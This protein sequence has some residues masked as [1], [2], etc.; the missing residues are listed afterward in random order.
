M[1]VYE[2]RCQNCHNR[3]GIQL[4]YAEYGVKAVACPVCGSDR[5]TRIHWCFGGPLR[6]VRE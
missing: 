3:V 4:S 6:P 1:P 2:F 5:L